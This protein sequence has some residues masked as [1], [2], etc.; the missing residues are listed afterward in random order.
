MNLQKFYLL[1]SDEKQSKIL[2][3]A[4]DL[5]VLENETEYFNQ[6]TWFEYDHKENSNFLFNEKKLNGIT[7]PTEPKK[8]NYNEIGSD[9]KLAFKW[10]T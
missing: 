6:G 10:V 5:E 1:Y 2:S 8:R 9:R 7:F 3:M 4:R